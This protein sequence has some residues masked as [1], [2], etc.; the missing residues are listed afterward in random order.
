LRL[1]RPISITFATLILFAVWMW[2]EMSGIEYRPVS[3][4][5]ERT[6]AGWFMLGSP[7]LLGFGLLV[8]LLFTLIARR[9][10][11]VVGWLCLL[12]VFVPLISF[13]YSSTTPAA[14]LRTALGSQP[15]VGT[16]IRRIEQYDS[17]N[18]GITI[19]GV[20]S[21]SP[22]FVQTLITAH[23]LKA[24]HSDGL[25]R[26]MLRDEPIPE[27]VTVLA[28]D[29]LTIWYDADQSLLYFCRRLGQPRQP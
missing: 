15:P 4:V 25:L 9:T 17:F 8:S 27:E 2:I 6:T 11:P 24:S 28:G 14:R 23:S 18:E 16:Q 26:Q 3:V 7:F 12:V 29:Q 5:K 19:A 21:G 10:R 22:Q 13:A 1:L 20:C